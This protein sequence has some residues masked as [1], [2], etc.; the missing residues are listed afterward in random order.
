M[1]GELTDG[2]SRKLRDT[3][4][5]AFPIYADS[6]VFQGLQEPCFF[7]S[8]TEAYRYPLPGGRQR[9][10]IPFDIAF[11][12]R[13]R[14]CYSEMWDAG[15]ALFDAL[16]VV[17][18]GDGSCVRG[19]GR[20]YFISEGILHFSVTFAVNLAPGIDAGVSGEKMEELEVSVLSE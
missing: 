2:I 6:P 10:R 13:D 5:G 11:F 20:R 9:V 4:Q 14:E 8:L 15:E 3:F 18:L 7:V 12:P 1:V 17:P 16:E 19:L